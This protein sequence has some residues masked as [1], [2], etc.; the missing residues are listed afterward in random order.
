MAACTGDDLKSG[1]KRLISA[2]A[3]PENADRL[4]GCQVALNECLPRT[5]TRQLTIVQLLSL[6][7]FQPFQYSFKLIWSSITNNFLENK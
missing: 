4:Q 2:S 7:Y 6:V 5:T 3:S 1:I